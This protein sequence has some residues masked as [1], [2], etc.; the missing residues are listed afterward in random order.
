MARK[1]IEEP[2][3]GSIDV[4]LVPDEEAGASDETDLILARDIFPGQLPIIPLNHR[5]LFPKMQVP[6]IVDNDP[7]KEMLVETFEANSKFVGLVLCKP[8]E[9]EEDRPTKGSDLYRVGV[10]A[11]I[12]DLQ[13]P[14][15]KGP[16]QVL[17]GALERFRVTDIIRESPHIVATVDYLFETEMARND[18]LKAYSLAVVKSLKELIQLNPLHRE[19]MALL[20]AQSPVNEPGRLADFAAAMTSSEPGELQEVL[21][22][23]RIRTRLGKVLLLL[24]KEI[25]ISKL[26]VK[27]SKQIEEKLTTQ[28]RQFFLREQLKA[29]KKELGLEKEGK[30]ADAERF[31]KRIKKLTLTDEARERI[32]E[33][34]AKIKLIEPA[35]PEFNVSRTYLDWLTILPWGVFTKDRY[36]IAKAGR[37]LNRDHYGLEDVKDRILEF[38]SVGIMKGN[39]SGTILCFVGPPGVGKTSIGKS[40]ARSIG[41]NFFRFSLGGIQ[42][43][44][45]IKGH[46]RTYIGAL[47]GKFIQ[48]M[49]T[50]KSANPVIMLDEI[51]KIGQSYRGDPA[52]ALLEVLD[53][54]QNSDFLDHYL[55]VRFDLSNVFF[56]CTA[57][58]LDTIPRALLD[59]MEIIKLSGYI[60]EEKLQIARRYLLPKQLKAHGVTRSQLTITSRGLR[61]IID[62]YARE[63]GVRGVENHIKRII[64][65]S[66]KRI[67]E[68]HNDK[69]KIDAADIEPLLGKPVF[70]DDDFFKNPG[71]GV[72]TGLAWTSM[73]GDTLA[74]EATGVETGKPGFK[75]TGQLGAV[76]VESTEIAYTYIRGFLS[77]SEK[78]SD[79]LQKQFIHLHIPAGATPKDGPSAGITMASALYSLATGKRIRKAFAMTGELTLTGRVMPIGGVKEKTIAAKRAGIN[80]LVFPEANRKDFEEL[81]DHVRKGLKP[82]YV[83]TF[84]EVVEICF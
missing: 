9:G 69:I 67:V 61:K 33:E 76:M 7:L 51:D 48:A 43:E 65:K 16:I 58:Q 21:A 39:I 34:M 72:V 82:N 49:K 26:Q 36:D 55:D 31:E 30:E 29:I 6:M 57:N 8:K 75:Q 11:E 19:E 81:P 78:A 56:I 1:K 18:E 64:R 5:P 24:Q 74:I 22:A 28:Q 42:D 80:N 54:E 47:P 50:C 63:P 12:L 32:E 44:A 52:S 23:I 83:S 38:L 14:H 53:P 37:I 45:E 84:P 59:R 10:I 68:G 27:I 66:V 20:M 25:D 4:E 73:G 41:R 71:V 40:I 62:G 17:L 77:D 2:D 13:Q 70:K 15:P 3:D 46:R 60:L 79:V 35:S